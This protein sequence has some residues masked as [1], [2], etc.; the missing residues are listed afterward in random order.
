MTR[1]AENSS[2]SLI[3]P[4]AIIPFL[5][6]I[7]ALSLLFFFPISPLSISSSTL[8]HS[9][10]SPFFCF[11]NIFHFDYFG[12]GSSYLI[13]DPHLSLSF[14]K[15][16][17]SRFPEP[18]FPFSTINS[19][20]HSFIVYTHLILHSLIHQLNYILIYGSLSIG[21]FSFH[22]GEFG[23]TSPKLYRPRLT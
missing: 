16:F 14:L 5:I 13:W 19:R 11:F 7:L 12:F 1:Q 8:I 3:Y 4:P 15:Y 20:R 23:S 2:R 17:V 21:F 10:S 18:V 22:T 9:L 6:L